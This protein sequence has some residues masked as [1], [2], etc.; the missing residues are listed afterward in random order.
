MPEVN[1]LRKI[2]TTTSSGYF[3]LSFFYDDAN[4]KTNIFYITE[5]HH[6]G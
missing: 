4:K 6:D 2:M 5:Q 3:A 1:D